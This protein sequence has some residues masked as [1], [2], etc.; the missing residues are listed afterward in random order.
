MNECLCVFLFSVVADVTAVT[1]DMAPSAKLQTVFG[2]DDVRK[3]LLPAG[4]PSTL[5]DLT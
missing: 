2:D 3:L 5:Q 1:V 4:I